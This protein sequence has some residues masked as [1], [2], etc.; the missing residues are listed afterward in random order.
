MTGHSYGGACDTASFGVDQTKEFLG[1]P[2]LG[3][4][5]EYARV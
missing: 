3:L 5:G 4:G 1:V 2:L